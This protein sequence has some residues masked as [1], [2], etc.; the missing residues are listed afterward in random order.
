MNKNLRP[1]FS[2]IVKTTDIILDQIQ[3]DDSADNLLVDN[4]QFEYRIEKSLLCKCN[5]NNKSEIDFLPN[6]V[7]DQSRSSRRFLRK[8]CRRCSLCG[9]RILPASPSVDSFDCY[10]PIEV[11]EHRSKNILD[12]QMLPNSSISNKEFTDVT[13]SPVFLGETANENW[14]RYEVARERTKSL[15]HGLVCTVDIENTSNYKFDH[16]FEDITINQSPP[17][18]V[19]S[20]QTLLVDTCTSNIADQFRDLY[21]AQTPSRLPS[22]G[23][24]SLTQIEESSTALPA[25]VLKKKS[26]EDIDA[27]VSK[28]AQSTP[29]KLPRFFSYVLRRRKNRRRLDKLREVRSPSPTCVYLGSTSSIDKL[30]KSINIPPTYDQ[31]SYGDSSNVV[32]RKNKSSDGSIKKMGRTQSSSLFLLN[33]VSESATLKRNRRYSN[34]VR[35]FREMSNWR[36]SEKKVSE[37]NTISEDV[38][39]CGHTSS[40]RKWRLWFTRKH[41]RRQSDL[42]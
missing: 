13:E 40:N 32:L 31:F 12:N 9:G 18:T 6:S 22:S 35:L 26:F 16:T 4:E 14:F 25:S 7:N 19:S 15:N 2:E 11:S 24:S 30:S 27:K 23:V 17:V 1:T 41:R 5:N 39:H 36:L 37:S 42:Q 21:L 34:P 20:P 33:E 38:K 8:N 28:L 3:E 29:G 10:S